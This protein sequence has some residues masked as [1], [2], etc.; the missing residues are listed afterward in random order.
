MYGKPE[1]LVHE[2]V[3]LVLSQICFFGNFEVCK[4]LNF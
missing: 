2:G 3:S 1:V 4:S